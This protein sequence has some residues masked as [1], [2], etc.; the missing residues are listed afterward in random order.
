M[1]GGLLIFGDRTDTIDSAFFYGRAQVG[2]IPAGNLN[3][4][5]FFALICSYIVFSSSLPNSVYFLFE[6]VK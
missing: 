4:I 6:Y 3:Y 2:K 5:L 1:V